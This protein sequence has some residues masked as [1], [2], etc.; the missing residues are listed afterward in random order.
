M[1]SRQALVYKHSLVLKKASALSVIIARSWALKALAKL[2][3]GVSQFTI[4]RVVSC[5]DFASCHCCYDSFIVRSAKLVHRS[6]V[7]LSIEHPSRRSRS[8]LTI[9]CFCATS[10][11]VL[12][13]FRLC[14]CVRVCSPVT[15]IHGSARHRHL[16][17]ECGIH[18]Q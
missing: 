15:M 6:L 4:F 1:S 8:M 13:S 3:L 14:S 12:S 9:V 2:N 7:S 17:V 5:H 10:F 11:P 16:A 18:G